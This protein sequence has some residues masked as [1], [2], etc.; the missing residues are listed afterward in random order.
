[1]YIK[2]EKETIYYVPSYNWVWSYEFLQS[3]HISFN[4]SSTFLW[5]KHLNFIKKF[6]K[7]A[8]LMIIIVPLNYSFRDVM[9]FIL[10]SKTCSF[11]SFILFLNIL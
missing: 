11:R 9:Q 1:M 2:Q 6:N 8:T 3:F 7:N 4:F 5:W 10:L